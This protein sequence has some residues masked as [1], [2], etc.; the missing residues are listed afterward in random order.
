MFHWYATST[1]FS[2][3]AIEVKQLQ[4]YE[5]FFHA[6]FKGNVHDPADANRVADVDPMTS[7]LV[8][9][10]DDGAT[11]ADPSAVEWQDIRC[12]A[13]MVEDMIKKYTHDIIVPCLAQEF[14]TAEQ[15]Q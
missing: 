2:H 9:I 8:V 13:S 6:L 4:L 15:V 5:T 14:T 12:T 10:E 1:H 11:A 3:C 7:S